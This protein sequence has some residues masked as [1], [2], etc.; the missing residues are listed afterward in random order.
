MLL[1]GMGSLCNNHRHHSSGASGMERKHGN[2]GGSAARDGPGFGS[3]HV[4][5]RSLREAL[6]QPA[7]SG[8]RLREPTGLSAPA[9]V[10]TGRCPIKNP[11]SRQAP[12]VEFCLAIPPDL[13]SHLERGASR[14]SEA[15][16]QELGTAGGIAIDQSA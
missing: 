14:D 11:R 9:Q 13:T 16:G 15:E 7:A 2:D 8:S 10:Q 5:Q 12:G 1:A 4:A 6:E 3:E